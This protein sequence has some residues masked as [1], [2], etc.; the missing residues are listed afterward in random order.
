[1][2]LPPISS[3]EECIARLPKQVEPAERLPV[4]GP[5]TPARRPRTK[6]AEDVRRQAQQWIRACR[7]AIEGQGG[8][9]GEK[10]AFGV[11]IGLVKGFLLPMHEAL[12]L[13]RE[14]NATCRPPFSEAE[15]RHKI[16]D[17]GRAPDKQVAGWHLR[18]ARPTLRPLDFSALRAEQ[19][20]ETQ[21]AADL[22]AGLAL[23]G[24]NGSAKPTPEPPTAPQQSCQRSEMTTDSAALDCRQGDREITV[25]FDGHSCDFL[26]SE[27]LRRGVPIDEVIRDAVLEARS[28]RS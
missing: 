1:M 27:A 13:M 28:R 18:S 9:Q 21:A 14:W 26:S 3:L 2:A 19:E 20:A 10:Q 8:N 22:P 5:E 7:P 24:R 23:P 11:A 16:E 4:P 15:L 17:A 12:E 25:V 6:K